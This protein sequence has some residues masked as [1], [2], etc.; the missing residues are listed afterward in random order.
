MSRQDA[1]TDEQEGHQVDTPV[2][3]THLPG[4]ELQVAAWLAGISRVLKGHN[5][6]LGAEM[7][8]RDRQWR[9]EQGS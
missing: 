2:S 4:R 7:C 6:A 1:D 9:R 8:I 5:E 3:Y